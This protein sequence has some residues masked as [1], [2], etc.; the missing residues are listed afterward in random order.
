MEQQSSVGRRDG[1][2]PRR[3]GFG[4]SRPVTAIPARFVTERERVLRILERWTETIQ[5]SR[6]LPA[7]AR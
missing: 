1:L 5:V 6:S 3:A 4:A 7:P 2:G